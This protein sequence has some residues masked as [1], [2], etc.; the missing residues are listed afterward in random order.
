MFKYGR[1]VEGKVMDDASMATI[2]SDRAEVRKG[3]EQEEQ[4]K[5]AVA[6][7]T[8]KEQSKRQKGQASGTKKRTKR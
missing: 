4:E 1:T 7:E 3:E 2:T 5:D 8:A 6:Q